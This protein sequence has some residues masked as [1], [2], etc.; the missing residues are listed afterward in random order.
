VNRDLAH[1][2]WI[3]G[4]TDA[5][6]TSVAEALAARHGWQVY[7][8]DRFDRLEPPG[9]WARIDPERHPNLL[10][11]R[12]KRRDEAWVDTTPEQM[13]AEWLRTTPER[14]DLTLEDLRARPAVPPIVA[15]GYG[16]LP[17]LV[18]PL[19]ATTRQ[20]IWLVSTEE[21][22][23]ASYARRGKGRFADTRDPERAR[24]NHVGRDLLLAEEM[25]R[26]ARELGLTVVE[27]DGTGSLDEVVALVE[28]H[29]APY[30]ATL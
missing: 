11:A 27:I 6:K 8:Y 16:F 5:G 19:L 12:G 10:V 23:R 18:R 20:A 26:Q 21:F 17:E 7:H 22:K 4:A 24:R 9:H 3:G 28:E 30:V 25:R 14:F 2:L 1:V 13:V 29:F 15:E